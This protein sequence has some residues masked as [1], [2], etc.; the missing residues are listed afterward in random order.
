MEND[1][2]DKQAYVKL[3]TGRG[4]KLFSSILKDLKESESCEISKLLSGPINAE[5]I[6]RINFCMGKKKAYQTVLAFREELCGEEEN[7]PKDEGVKEVQ[8]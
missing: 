6:Q 8:E 7:S 5:G 3:F 4:W 1:F 2:Q